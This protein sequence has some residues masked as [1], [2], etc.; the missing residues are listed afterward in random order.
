MKHFTENNNNKEFI[1]KEKENIFFEFPISLNNKEFIKKEK[2]NNFFEFPSSNNSIFIK[3]DNQNT[4][5]NTTK[6]SEEN[7]K[8]NTI[9]TIVPVCKLKPKKVD[10]T[11]KNIKINNEEFMY[12]VL[13]ISNNCDKDRNLFPDCFI[14]LHYE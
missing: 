4:K 12:P 3:C 2:E 9:E 10:Q 13:T 6:P 5:S 7:I 14:V 11:K 1:K 8:K